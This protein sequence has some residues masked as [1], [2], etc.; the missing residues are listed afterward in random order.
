MNQ[1][2]EMPLRISGGTGQLPDGM[3][4]AI[5]I[6]YAGAPDHEDALAKAVGAIRAMGYVFD[7]LE[8]G[9]VFNIPIDQWNEAVLQK[10]DF[11]SENLPS[12]DELPALIASGQVFLG[13]FMCY[14]KETK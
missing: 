8:G 11:F 3:N 5:A 7:D 2:W 13:P 1:L 6:V 14:S 10:Y 4:G 9:S 12:D